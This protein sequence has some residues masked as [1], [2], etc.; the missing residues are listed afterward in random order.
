MRE[1]VQ[2]TFW[3]RFSFIR[4]FRKFL[5]ETKKWAK[6]LKI[7]SQTKILGKGLPERVER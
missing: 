2:L 4:W 7:S 3:V 5:Q 6:T 1:R